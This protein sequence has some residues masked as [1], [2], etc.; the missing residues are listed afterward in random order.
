MKRILI[1]GATGFIGRHALSTL[2][3]HDYEVFAVSRQDQ[4]AP[5]TGVNW[6][7]ADL[8]DNGAMAKLIA[9]LKPTHL[10]H[11]AWETSPGEY[12]TSP[13]N[14]S[15]LSASLNL[16]NE[17]VHHGGGRLVVAGTCAEYSWNDGYCVERRTLLESATLYGA[18][19]NALR[20]VAQAFADQTGLSF[21]WGRIFYLYG[22]HENQKRLVPAVVTPLLQGM[23]VKCSHGGQIR[24]FLHVQDVADAFVALLDSG[25]S[26][27][28]NI[29]SG[30]PVS[31]KDLV[32]TIADLIGADRSLIKLGA[33]EA[34]ADDPDLLVADIGRLR[35]QVGWRPAYALAAGLKHTID[36]HNQS[37]C[38][39]LDDKAG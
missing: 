29:G 17:F 1:T 34:R 36:W 21:A 15:W 24:D 9:Y 11:L 10:L 12:W 18:S 20:Q 13:N 7:Q 32:F 39:V 31:I 23:P 5:T 35:D 38:V 37:R 6:Y 22:P 33:L 8:F 14:L 3:N 27:P 4:P 2:R 16:I 19:K 28:V 25:V 30:E 26:G